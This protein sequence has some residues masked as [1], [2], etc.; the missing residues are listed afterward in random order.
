MPDLSPSYPHSRWRLII[1]KAQD[2]ATNMAIDEAIAEHVG[3][4]QVPPTLR[5]YAWEPACLSLGYA[6]SI[7]DVDYGR[8]HRRG[9]DVV[10]RLTGGRAIL[11]VDEIT[12]SVAAPLDEP[13][14]GGGVIESYRRLSQGLLLGLQNLGALVHAER[15]VGNIP[16]THGP[17]C[18]EVPSDYEITAQGKKLFGSAQTRRFGTIL[19]HGALP[20]YGDITRICDALVFADSTER[21]EARERVRGRALTLEE[22]LG[23]QLDLGPVSDALAKGFEQ[24]M[25]LEFEE[26][27]IT[28][29]EQERAIELRASKYAN[30]E[31]TERR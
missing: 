7:S 31:W 13:R 23:R 22:A 1:H 15:T 5:F 4:G 12:Y 29:Q 10:R 19:Q 30:P 26:S 14:V 9:W 20:L 6:Q 11:H 25:N 21:E 28:T 27:P 18:F 8:L 3:V 16:R 2:G 24:A 17:V